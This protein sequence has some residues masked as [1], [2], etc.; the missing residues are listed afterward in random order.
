MCSKQ[1]RRFKLAKCTYEYGKYVESIIDNSV[2][3]CDEIIDVVPS[4]T[5]ATRVKSYYKITKTVST[6]NAS[7]K[8]TSTNFYILLIFLLITLV[9]LIAASFYCYLIKYQWKQKYLL[10]NQISSNELKEINIDNTIQ[11]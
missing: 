9:L 11:N 3:T 8:I 1:N 7:T 6:K 2:I 4:A 10:L 5:L